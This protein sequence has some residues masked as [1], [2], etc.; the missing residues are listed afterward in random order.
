M[1]RNWTRFSY[2]HERDESVASPDVRRGCFKSGQL[3][4]DDIVEINLLLPSQWASDLIELSQERG[5][6]SARSFAR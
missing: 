5:Q 1:E 6:I 2:V 3:W 4:H